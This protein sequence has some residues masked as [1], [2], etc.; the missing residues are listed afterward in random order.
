LKVE[1]A[2]LTSTRQK[3]GVRC[4]LSALKSL[5]STLLRLKYDVVG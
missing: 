5:K 2:S 1:K 3:K 4:R